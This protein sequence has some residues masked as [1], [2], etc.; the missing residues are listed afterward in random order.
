MGERRPSRTPWKLCPLTRDSLFPQRP[1][2]RLRIGQEKRWGISGVVCWEFS[3]CHWDS[4]IVRMC[5][6]SDVRSPVSGYCLT[7]PWWLNTEVTHPRL[8]LIWKNMRHSST[9]RRTSSWSSAY[10][11]GARE[12]WWVA[13]GAALSESPH[14][15]AS[16]PIPTAPDLWWPSWRRERPTY[17]IDTFRI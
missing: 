5:N 1:P 8:Y 10:P 17:G 2:G 16:A 12:G 14:E 6:P 9:R 4:L 13:Q 11:N 7:S 3:L 15:K